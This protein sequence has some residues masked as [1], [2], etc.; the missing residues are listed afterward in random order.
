MA[1]STNSSFGHNKLTGRINRPGEEHISFAKTLQQS[2][3][4]I[5]LLFSVPVV[6]F[7]EDHCLGSAN[8]LL[9]SGV[10]CYASNY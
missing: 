7:V 10:K 4:V 5:H 9:T 3:Q 1:L 2:L 8:L 6:T